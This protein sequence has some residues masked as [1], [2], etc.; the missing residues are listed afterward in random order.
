MIQRLKIGTRLAVGFCLILLCAAAILAIG[1]WRMAELQA[2]SEYVIGKKVAGMTT[3]MN[4]R[5]SGSELALALRKVVTPTDAAEGKTEDAHLTRLLQ[6]Y[7]GAERRLSA[8]A[9]SGRGKELLDGAVADSKKLFPVVG[10]IREQVGSGNYFDAAQ[11]LKSDFLPAHEKWMASV[12]ALASFQQDDMN[13]AHADAK[14]SY[15]KA[16]IGMLVIGVFTLGL[17]IFFTFIITNSITRPLKRAGNIAET[18]SSG[19]LTQEFSDQ[20]R[21]EAATLVNSLGAMQANLAT[22]LN[23]VKESAAIIAVASHEI[24]RGNID[25]SNRTESQASSLEET[26]SSMEQLTS[27][28]QQ[29]A[30]NARQANQLVVSASDYASKGGRVVSDVVDTMGSIKESSRKIVDIIGVIDGIAFQTNILALNAAV[31]A[32]R[33]GEQGRG[34]A[35]VASEV[36]S[37]AQRSASAAKEIKGLIGDS[38]EKVDA[39]GKLVDEAGATMNEIVTS[40]R[41]VADIMG[42]ITAAS[43]E[44]SAGIA[45][46]NNAIAQ[47]DEITQQNAALVEEAAAAAESLQEQSD[48]LAHAVSVFRLRVEQGAGAAAASVPPVSPVASSRAPARTVNTAPAIEVKVRQVPAKTAS[49][50]PA[51]P[52]RRQPVRDDEFEEF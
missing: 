52:S 32:A 14:E 38:V 51:A 44:Q 1:L 24:A 19:D 16:Q 46:V 12:G 34:F 9:D 48:A 31:E 21:D 6:A 26:A 8:L 27:T 5:E 41:H 10:T 2:S 47:I 17:G 30:E 23:E 49:L 43:A 37:L 13:A 20:G 4:M 45:E 25:L 33:A 39:G 15:R 29:N 3:A 42:E 11:L 18:I 50:P 36:R 28:V 7:A 22:T 40:V 35:V